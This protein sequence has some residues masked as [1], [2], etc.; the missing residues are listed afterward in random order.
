MTNKILNLI[1]PPLLRI[2]VLK[3]IIQKK[4]RDKDILKY[5]KNFYDRRSFIN[6][7][8]C[9]RNLKDCKYLEI[10]VCKN[11]VFNTIPLSI[12]NKI[13]VDPFE[14]GTHRME[15]DYFFLKNKILFDV[16]FIDGQHTYEQCQNDCI[17]ALKYLKDDGIIFLHDLLPKNSFEAAVPRKQTRW[18]GNVWKVAAELIVSENLRFKIVNIDNGVGILKKNNNYVYNKIQD[19]KS[20]NFKDYKNNYLKKFPIINCAEAIEF[21]DNG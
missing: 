1:L 21:I 10:G 4:I 9:N 3:E 19:L 8:I 17:N 7:A 11:E 2:S 5:E 14:G 18:T 15:S 20:S 16:I 12:K 6:R 13:G